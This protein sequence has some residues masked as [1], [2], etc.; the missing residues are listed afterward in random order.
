VTIGNGEASTDSEVLGAPKFHTDRSTYADSLRSWFASRRPEA[1]DVAVTNIDIPVNTGF[2]NETVFFDADW[3]EGGSDR[4]HRFVAR[5]EPDNGALFPAQTPR[6]EVSVELQFLA[7]SAVGANSAVPV[8]PLVGYEPDPRVLGGAFFVM[9]F[10]AT[11]RRAS[12]STR[13]RRTSDAPWS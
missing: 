6:S 7:M 10:P 5:I 13:P 3:R 1:R 4:H 8:P 11:P 12:W 2:S 9:E